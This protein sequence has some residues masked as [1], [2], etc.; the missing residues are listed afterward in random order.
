MPWIRVRSTPV[1]RCSSPPRS[2]RGRSWLA[3]LLWFFS[4]RGRQTVGN[5]QIGK[6]AFVVAGRT[7]RFAFDTYR[8]CRLLAPVQTAVP[9]A[10]YLQA[11]SNLF[12]TGVHAWIAECSRLS[13]ITFASDDCSYDGLTGEPTYIADHVCQLYVHLGE[14]LLHSQYAGCRSRDM[15]SPLPPVGSKHSNLGRRLK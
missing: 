3:S 11:F 2:K 8:T 12:L 5:R 4:S 13:W 10:N 14:D 7:R 1:T 9:G 15:F 6:F